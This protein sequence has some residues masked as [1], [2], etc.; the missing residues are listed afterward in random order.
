MVGGGGGESILNLL[1]K[2][3][4]KNTI[5]E[6]DENEQQP[7]FEQNHNQRN[8]N[9]QQQQPNRNSNQQAMLSNRS[10]NQL[11]RSGNFTGNLSPNDFGFVPF[12]RTNEFL[13]PAHAGSPVPPSRESSAVKKDRERARQVNSI[14]MKNPSPQKTSL[15]YKFKYF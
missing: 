4:A 8:T 1:T 13:N 12:L 14:E 11:N 6:E 15:S 9:Q 10:D 5:Y 2:N 3:L 7:T